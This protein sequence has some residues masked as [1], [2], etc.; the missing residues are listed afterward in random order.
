MILLTIRLHPFA[1]IADQTFS[2]NSGM[3]V[4]YGPN[5]FGKSTMVHALHHVLFSPTLLS[6]KK[7]E[8]LL[9]DIQPLNGSDTVCVTLQFS[10]G[11]DLYTLEKNW[12][13]TASS[14]LTKSDGSILTDG[15]KIQEQILHMLPSNEA[16]V[17]QIMI[18]N[19]S[20]L[21][22][23]VNNMSADAQ[24]SLSE[25]LRGAI[26]HGGGIN[27]TL[28]QQTIENK[29]KEYF[30]RWD[31]IAGQ[32]EG[33]SGRGIHNPWQKDK[34]YILEAWYEWENAKL[35]EEETKNFEEESDRIQR[36]IN[37][38]N[39]SLTNIHSFLEK[40]RKPYNETEQRIR[41]ENDKAKFEKALEEFSND[42][43]I[44]PKKQADKD[45]KEKILEQLE[46]ELGQI[47][48]ELKIAEKKKEAAGDII[49]LKNANA[50][51]LEITDTEKQLK[52]IPFVKK[53]DL[54][55]IKKLE[56]VR[57]RCQ[58]L[59]EGQKLLLNM[60]SEIDGSI[61]ISHSGNQ[62]D[63]I[64]FKKGEAIE[65]NVNGMI[66]W[67]WNGIY[68]KIQSANEDIETLKNSLEETDA[69]INKILN[70]YAQS[71]IKDLIAISE[72]YKQ[73]TDLIE[74]KQSNLNTLL[75]KETMEALTLRGAEANQLPDTR[76]FEY[77]KKLKDDKFRNI[78]EI[79][80]GVN[81]LTDD[82]RKL[83]EKHGSSENLDQRRL[84]GMAEVA[85]KNKEMENL[86]KVPEEYATPEAFSEDY[87]KYLKYKDDETNNKHQ[88]ELDLSNLKQPALSLQEA[89][90][91]TII[92]ENKYK[93]LLKEG[94]AYARIREVLNSML[95]KADDNAFLPLHQHTENY[96]QQL[97]RGRFNH[98]PFDATQ[99]QELAGPN[100]NIPVNRLSKGTK[101]LLALAFRLASADIYLESRRGFIVMDDPLVDMDQHRRIAAA[102]VLRNFAQH[103]QTIVLTCHEEHAKL[104]S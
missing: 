36:E 43:L 16:I 3:T 72:K 41:L 79:K 73:L 93:Q 53:E 9:K 18:A 65:K 67:E 104:L 96:L 82:I 89:S 28:L 94:Q 64:S 45:A 52:E 98:I 57:D 71:A 86:S 11:T 39:E 62:S 66:E 103:H 100:L 101:D 55:N 54:D 2:F 19:Q 76:D 37:Q 68:F 31:T 15:S 88:L 50:I 61:S 102:E 44:W 78:A 24:S 90:E 13:A 23:A 46:N 75:G 56:A 10:S 35:E 99:P 69:A 49:K 77:L 40:Y 33:G 95:A 22:A 12:G 21:A 7:M 42:A 4:V 32:P 14:K 38:H 30:K 80:A 70:S 29:V 81:Q 48:E 87:K 8:D 59:I 91:V 74:K 20:E 1:G 97:S 58:S 83:I 26:L 63:T 84:K 34:G 27:G 51:Q 85:N 17:R 92:A 25:K 5:E 47:T 6:Q 60:R